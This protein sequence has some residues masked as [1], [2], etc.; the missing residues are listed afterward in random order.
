MRILVTGSEGFIGKHVVRI[1]A[2]RGHEVVGCDI[3]NQDSIEFHDLSEFDA[4]I[5]LAAYIDIKESFEKP[6]DYIDNNLI[7]ISLLSDAKRVVFASSAAVYGDFS[8]YGYTKRLAEH[9]LPDNSIALRLF[10]PFGP[11][12]NHENETHLVPNLARGGAVLYGNGTQTRNFI[13]VRDAA[14]AF[15]LSAES[16]LTGT[17]NLGNTPLTLGEVAEL[18]NV[19]YTLDESPRD[20]ADVLVLNGETHHLWQLLNSKPQYDVKTELKNWRQW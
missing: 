9:V 17:Y 19:E 15:V 7:E 10:N 5:H 1:A 8:P 13:D 14:M 11:G 16:D 12:E 20:A 2:Q 18:M 4:V 3:K 6:W